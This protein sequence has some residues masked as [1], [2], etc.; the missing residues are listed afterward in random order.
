MHVNINYFDKSGKFTDST[1][2][3]TDSQGAFSSNFPYPADAGY[4]AVLTIPLIYHNDENKPLAYITDKEKDISQPILLFCGEYIINSSLDLDIQC[5]LYDGI[6]FQNEPVGTNEGTSSQTYVYFYQTMKEAVDYYQDTID[7]EFTARLPIR[8]IL[9]EN[10]I[11][12]KDY[13]GYYNFE[14]TSIHIMKKQST[15]NSTYMPNLIYHELSHHVMTMLYYPH[16]PGDIRLD[17]DTYHGGYANSSTGYS[18][19]EGF[20]FFMESIIGLHYYGE[21]AQN[22]GDL[23]VNHKTWENSGYSETLA[24]AS[25]L[26]DLVDT[27]GNNDE[28]VELP[29]MDLWK[30]LSHNQWQFGDIYDELKSTYPN[31]SAEIDQIFI[32]HGFY[33]VTDV[34]EAGAG[35]YNFGEAFVDLNNNFTYDEGETFVDYNAV[36]ANGDYIQEYRDGYTI[37]YAGYANNVDRK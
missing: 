3:V 36:D 37:G 10:I 34:Y 35:V 29:F 19:S 6:A 27:D 16:Y 2:V 21:P 11:S 17:T 31:L 8:F 24:V 22:L 7:F 33:V 12:V 9:N 28:S 13:M 5:D 25:V 20:A 26:Y 23:E 1:S 4:A 15:L 14:L 18:Y 32:D 30:I